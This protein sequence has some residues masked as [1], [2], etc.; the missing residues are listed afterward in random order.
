MQD[1]V[2]NP[3][4]VSEFIDRIN[5]FLVET[6]RELAIKVG[7]IKIIGDD[8]VFDP[9]KLLDNIDEPGGIE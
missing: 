8:D 3:Q 1:A 5:S 2:N 4:T 7:I 6:D 9:K